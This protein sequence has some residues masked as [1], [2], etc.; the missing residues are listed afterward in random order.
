[1]ATERIDIVVTA[2]GVSV[3]RS[4]L[5]SIGNASGLVAIQVNNLNQRIANSTNIFNRFGAGLRGITSAL[6]A[7]GGAFSL[8]GLFDQLDRVSQIR[9][10]IG[11][12]AV[13]GENVAN[14]F[15]RLA[16][17][18]N[19]ARTPLEDTVKSYQRI[20]F[21]LQKLGR[22]S[23]DT[24]K[25]TNLLSKAYQLSG[26]TANEAAQSSR[27]FAQAI[28]SGRFGEQELRSVLEEGPGVA[29]AIAEGFRLT[30]KEIAGLKAGLDGTTKFFTEQGKQLDVNTTTTNK[31]RQAISSAGGAVTVL[32]QKTTQLSGK[33]KLSNELLEKLIKNQGVSVAD[34]KTLSQNEF[35]VGTRFVDALERSGKAIEERFAKLPVTLSQAIIV[36]R[37]QI[38]VLFFELDESTGITNKLGNAILSLSKNIGVLEGVI[39]GLAVV[40]IPLATLALGKLT[41]AIAGTGIGLL[42]IGLGTASGLLIAYRKEIGFAADGT[43]TFSKAVFSLADAFVLIGR[44]FSGAKI[45]EIGKAFAIPLASFGSGG[46]PVPGSAAKGVDPSKIVAS[47][48]SVRDRGDK[49]F[50]DDLPQF[51]RLDFIDPLGSASKQFETVRVL[52]DR[53]GKVFEDQII[54]DIRASDLEDD[55]RNSLNRLRDTTGQ[56][57]S[58]D[59]DRRAAKLKADEQKELFESRKNFLGRPNE[60]RPLSIPLEELLKLS[61]KEVDFRKLAESQLKVELQERKALLD[62][63]REQGPELEKLERLERIRSD[64]AK[65]ENLVG[66]IG[67]AALGLTQDKAARRRSSVTNI[68]EEAAKLFAED[69]AKLFA[70]VDEKAFAVGTGL[71]KKILEGAT[72]GAANIPEGSTPTFPFLEDIVGKGQELGEKFS[73]DFNEFA[74]KRQ[75]GAEAFKSV[76]GD[77]LT[78][79][80]AKAKVVGDKLPTD[81]FNSKV[82]T[83]ATTALFPVASRLKDIGT[84]AIDAGQ[85]TSATITFAERLDEIITNIRK[86]IAGTIGFVVGAIGQLIA[87]LE[88]AFGRLFN[89]LKELV[90]ET[91]G[92]IGKIK[93][94]LADLRPE[95]GSVARTI[96]AG[97]KLRD[98]L[99]GQVDPTTLFGDAARS[100]VITTFL[101]DVLSKVKGIRKEVGPKPPPFDE[102]DK[103]GGSLTFEQQLAGLKKFSVPK[104]AE[105][106]PK[107]FFRDILKG[108]DEFG[109]LF[110]STLSNLENAIVSFTT[111]GR[112]NFKSFVDAMIADI[113]RFALRTLILKPLL[114]LAAG[115]QIGQLSETGTDFFRLGTSALS[116]LFGGGSG[117]TG[118][119]QIPAGTTFGGGLGPGGFA[120]G[121]LVSG[122]GGPTS[123]S[124]LARLSPGEFVVNAEATSRN[125]GLLDFVNA[126]G[127]AGETKSGGVVFAPTINV[128]VESSGENGTE[129][130]QAVASQLRT[131]IQA[132][133]SRLLRT[134]TRPGGALQ[135]DRATL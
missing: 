32:Q 21:A 85:K 110:T 35:L 11:A 3:V 37:N 114:N 13:E 78:D 120:A 28:S 96:L 99:V 49:G 89:F 95:D 22:S 97:Q 12:I 98:E 102:D 82:G 57:L 119:F 42:L 55:R 40:A 47:T 70:G 91:L 66:G 103:G 101:D 9:A 104:E 50:F 69:V 67:K 117:N 83:A 108:A 68:A 124:L 116:G 107:D 8:K 38:D 25:I 48:A 36:V 118:S 111:T 112:F 74:T 30:E 34:L 75:Q 43:L 17:S 81:L 4:S 44:A 128:T 134:E 92:A 63:T 61:Q 106:E 41:L 52:A 5:L 59:I 113:T 10:R 77:V 62:I 26:S 122:P 123:D 121:G 79:L 88:N 54:Q 6:G 16:A 127:S 31:Y 24:I 29:R 56:P 39:T 18:A 1:M 105:Q 87:E 125:R 100:G 53:A 20:G 80:S 135:R 130:G 64:A 73:S 33:Q 72:S 23:E 84:A 86:G 129:Q 2:T 58:V 93:L 131:V 76:A 14:T 60:R 126:G 15:R 46:I 65:K 7:L 90:N 94:E 19:D 51:N 109:Q 45:G 133:F 27:Q 71:P 115:T 132:E